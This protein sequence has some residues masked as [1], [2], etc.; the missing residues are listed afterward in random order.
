MRGPL[1]LAFVVL[2]A[3]PSFIFAA[4]PE[5]YTLI[6]KVVKIAD[7]DTLTILNSANAQHWIRLA[8]IDAPEK[9]QPFGTKS[10][11]NLAGKVFG[12]LVRVEVIDVDRCRTA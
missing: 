10:R 4:I 9:A 11:E 3:L 2:V 5:P 7:G 12:Q 1:R 8:G 6:G